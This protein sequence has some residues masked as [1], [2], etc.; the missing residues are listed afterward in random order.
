LTQAAAGADLPTKGA[1]DTLTPDSAVFREYFGL[2]R[3]ALALTDQAHLSIVSMNPTYWRTGLRA[4][5]LPLILAAALAASCGGGSSFGGVFDNGRTIT[6]DGFA[7]IEVVESVPVRVSQ[8][9][10]IPGDL[11]VA[12]GAVAIF[13]ASARDSQERALG[14]LRFE[15]R[16]ANGIAGTVSSNGVFTASNVPGNYENALEVVAI[17]EVDGQEFTAVGRASI[18]VTSGFFDTVIRS[19]VVFPSASTGRSGDF[20]PFRA[21]AIGDRGGLVQDIDLF[22]RVTDPAAG[23]IGPNGG[24]I[25]GDTP[26]TYPDAIEVQIRRLGGS[27]APV[28]GRATVQVLSQ[29]EASGQVRAL[30]G[31]T[32]AFGRP[33]GRAPLVLLT[34]DFN[35]RPVPTRSVVWTVLTPEAGEVDEHGVLTFGSTPGT[36]PASVQATATLAGDFDGHQAS[37]LLDV[38][39]QAPIVTGP[40]GIPGEALVFPQSVRIA[41]NEAVRLSALVFDE[42]GAAVTP[43]DL[44]WEYDEALFTVS[45]RGRLTTTAA[46]G[47]YEDALALNVQEA[48]GT[49]KQVLKTITVLGEMTRLEVTPQRATL[50]AGDAVL[51]LARAFDEANNQLQDVSFRW[52]VVDSASGTITRAGLYVAENDPGLHLGVVKVTASQRVAG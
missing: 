4:R 22:W 47:I 51:F 10:V 46:P 11:T 25:F 49:V 48:D 5:I 15:W 27:G 30:I 41:K 16:M 18:L 8:V 6:L 52:S 13:S 37:A 34:V 2:R 9:Q 20:V 21:A 14:G 44:D 1:F 7:D 24:F 26:G 35:G 28:V 36:Y 23:E 45:G 33:E 38:I 39:I 32:A 40:A 43:E 42:A 31:P 17:Q 12:R 50:G 3:E 29:A 19:A